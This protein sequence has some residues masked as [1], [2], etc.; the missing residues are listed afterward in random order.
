MYK[1]IIKTKSIPESSNLI[2]RLVKSEY[3]ND[4]K[5]VTNVYSEYN[6]V[7]PKTIN[8]VSP[9]AIN[10]LYNLC[11]SNLPSWEKFPK[12]NKSLI[13]GDYNVI[14]SRCK[15]DA[16]IMIVIP[17]EES[18]AV[19]PNG[20]IWDS[21]KY[22]DDYLDEFFDTLSDHIRYYL[23]KPID[24]KNWDNFSSILDEYDKVR[25]P[26]DEYRNYLN[27]NIDIISKWETKEISTLEILNA[28]L[29][30]TTNNFK[31]INYNGSVKIDPN[32]EMWTDSKSLLIEKS[33]FVGFIEKIIK[34]N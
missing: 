16:K 21:F 22:I 19:C 26:Y 3:Y 32:R 7:D 34:S 24:D 18:I 9:Y 1:T 5:I 10:N 2:Y 30:P 25:N 4:L 33:N 27:T 6:I 20:D 23:K 15:Y 8:R 13:G 29:D 28:I 12:R 31:I 14:N 11:L 17:L